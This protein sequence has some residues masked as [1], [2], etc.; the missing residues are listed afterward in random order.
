MPQALAIE[1]RVL[2]LFD[3]DPIHALAYQGRHQSIC[4]DGVVR[5]NLVVRGRVA[6]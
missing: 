6:I 2:R 1:T 3:A 4:V 5:R